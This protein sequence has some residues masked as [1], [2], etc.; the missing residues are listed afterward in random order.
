MIVPDTKHL[1][2]KTKLH[3]FPQAYLCGKISVQTI[4]G[5]SCNTE[6]MTPSYMHRKKTAK[7]PPWSK[8]GCLWVLGSQENW[9]LP[10]T[11]FLSFLKDPRDSH[12]S[13]GTRKEGLHWFKGVA[14]REA[15][16]WIK[17]N[18]EIRQATRQPSGVDTTVDW[19]DASTV[20]S[21][22]TPSETGKGWETKTVHV[23][24]VTFHTNAKANAFLICSTGTFMDLVALIIG[25]PHG[26]MRFQSL[27]IRMEI[28]ICASCMVLGYPFSLSEPIP[29]SEKLVWWR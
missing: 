4:E 23:K 12:H 28:S 2:T 9:S 22:L 1:T 16:V 20:R 8:C 10:C 3:F 29:I 17:L 21:G 24:M 26:T 11:P 6:Y 13:R 14:G 7:K 19:A 5:K 27:K 15:W 25:N 18:T